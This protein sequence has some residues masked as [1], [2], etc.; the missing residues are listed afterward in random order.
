M[1]GAVVV[2]TY[3]AP[4]FNRREILRYAGVRTEANGSGC[5][6]VRGDGTRYA[7]A[8]RQIQEPESVSHGISLTG[9]REDGPC[10]RKRKPISVDILPSDGQGRDLCAGEAEAFSHGNSLPKMSGA[11]L[12]AQTPELESLLEECLC[13]VE[14]QLA[15]RVCEREFPV[16]LC[17]DVL[18]L[19]FAETRSA[20]LKANLTGC[21]GIVLFAATVG[22]ALDRLIAKYSRISPARAVMLQAI[23]AERIESLCDVFQRE[24]AERMEARGCMLRPRFSP[25][26]GDFPLAMQKPIFDALD[27]PRKIG[28]SL[29]ESLLMSPSKSVTAVIGFVCGG[30]GQ[31]HT[32]AG[33]TYGCAACGRKDC[34]YRRKI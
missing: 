19:G 5:S 10:A 34:S 14:G 21:C 3:S 27:C 15:Y 33:K 26:Y 32:H 4:E 9:D 23:G 29:N 12:R 28:V 24:L 13:E 18:N 20:D 16:A 17:G 30:E 6:A 2:R 25:G 22:I 7:G 8:G 31:D 1:A 11:D